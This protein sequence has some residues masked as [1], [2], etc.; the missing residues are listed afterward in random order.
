MFYVFVFLAL[1]A[2]MGVLIVLRSVA[3]NPTVDAPEPVEQDVDTEEAPSDG[4]HTA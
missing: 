4:K 1:I 2:V 3:S